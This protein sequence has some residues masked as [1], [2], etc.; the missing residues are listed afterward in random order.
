[1]RECLN[2]CADELL[3]YC[4]REQGRTKH[5]GWR[6]ALVNLF[7]TTSTRDPRLRVIRPTRAKQNAHTGQWVTPDGLHLHVGGYRR[8]GHLYPPTQGAAYHPPAALMYILRDVLADGEHQAPNAAVAWPEPLRPRPHAL[9]PLWLVTT[10][11]QCARVAEQAQPWAEWVIVQVGAGQ[12]RPRGLFRGTTLLVATAVPHDPHMA[13]HA[14]EDQ[15]E[16][17]GHLVVHQR[18]G[19]AWPREHLTVLRSW[20]STVTGVEVRFHDHPATRPNDALA[21]SVGQ[22][23]QG[24][25][26]V[27]WQ[28]AALNAGWLSPTRY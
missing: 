8:Q 21:V 6:D 11:D 7:H 25:P 26:D 4:R 15:P 12:P 2:Q 22:L 1:M 19:L 20:V 17:T 16:D 14:L 24:H 10:H 18:G 5:R 27:K 23:T 9:T 28:S 13:V 3:H